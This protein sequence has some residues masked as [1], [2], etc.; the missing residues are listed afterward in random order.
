M[1][2]N[3]MWQKYDFNLTLQNKVQKVL[4]YTSKES[5]KNLA[6][7]IV[8][9]NCENWTKKYTILFD[10]ITLFCRECESYISKHMFMFRSCPLITIG[11]SNDNCFE[12]FALWSKK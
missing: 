11:S 1:L 7:N 5:A 6:T 3:T 8:G 9:S 4:F 10:F 12:P 2:P